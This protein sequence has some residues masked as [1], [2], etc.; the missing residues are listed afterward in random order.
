MAKQ[1]RVVSVVIVGIIFLLSHKT[2]AL[3]SEWVLLAEGH[4]NIYF[5]DITRIKH[6]SKNNLRVWIKR[7]VTEKEKERL[8]ALRKTETIKKI[9]N[10][11]EEI[12]AFENPVNKIKPTVR[13]MLQGLGEKK[14]Q[15]LEKIKICE[16]DY[17]KDL[18]PNKHITRDK[19]N[20]DLILRELDCLD[21]KTRILHLTKYDEK[22]N[23]IE[24]INVSDLK[25][26]YSPPGSLGEAFLNVLCSL[27][28]P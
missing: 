11:E 2:E 21:E 8:E 17:T 3:D 26:E 15:E 18:C 7:E 23:V 16:E 19:N 24:T 4:E 10:L 20:Y 25:W 12:K 1:N 27:K 13:Q 5:Y 28:S 9:K 14:S 6:T 22:R